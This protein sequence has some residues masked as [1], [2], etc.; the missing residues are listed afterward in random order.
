DPLG[1]FAEYS[2]KPPAVCVLNHQPTLGQ[3]PNY[4]YF[5][6]FGK[7]MYHNFV[8][9]HQ[10]VNP[11]SQYPRCAVLRLNPGGCMGSN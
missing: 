1:P 11:I 7:I 5:D 6:N 10:P 2:Q 9:T 8:V 4:S 3:T